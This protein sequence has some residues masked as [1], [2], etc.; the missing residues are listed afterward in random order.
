MIV[1]TV[2]DR[3]LEYFGHTLT[4]FYSASQKNPPLWFSDIFIPNG[5]EF[6]ISFCTPIT[7]SYLHQ[8]TKFYTI[9]FIFDEV[10]PY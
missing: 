7:L 10:M 5:W 2:K 4:T 9:I 3:Q 8:M 1:P 6:L